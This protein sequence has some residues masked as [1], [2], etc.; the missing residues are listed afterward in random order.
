MVDCGCCGCGCVVLWRCAG[1]EVLF[2]VLIWRSGYWG[3]QEG[4]EFGRRTTGDN[5]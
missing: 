2:E 1:F 4:V 3:F 5:R